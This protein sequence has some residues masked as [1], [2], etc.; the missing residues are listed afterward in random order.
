[1]TYFT[2]INRNVIDANR[3]Q[4]RN[5]PVVRFQ[6]GRHGAPTYAHRVRINGPSEVIYDPDNP[7]LPCGARLVIASE[8][9][10]EVI[11]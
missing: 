4:G 9:E 11:Q 8:I 10:P 1:M 3:K 6:R 2:H 7:I 5:D